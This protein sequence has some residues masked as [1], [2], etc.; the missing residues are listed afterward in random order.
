MRKRLAIVGGGIAGSYLAYLL[1]DEPLKINIFEKKKK[2]SLGKNCAWGLSLSHLRDF[3]FP[4]K[5]DDYILSDPNKDKIEIEIPLNGENFKTE[6]KLNNLVTID[7]NNFL[8]D[9]HEYLNNKSSIDID[10]ETSISKRSLE[11]YDYEMIVD[12]SGFRRDLLPDIIED[13]L[14]PCYQVRCKTKE[15][16]GWKAKFTGNGYLWRFP[17]N[18]NEVYIGCGDTIKNPRTCVEK[19]IKSMDIDI[20]EK[21]GSLIRLYPPQELSKVSTLGSSVVFGVGES[22]GT[23]SPITGE[24]IISSLKSA[25]I[26]YNFFD[27]LNFSK[28]SAYIIS[29]DFKIKRNKYED[30]VN[31]KFKKYKYEYKAFD[32]MKKNNLIS[33]LYN[34]I[35]MGDRPNVN[36]K[37]LQKMRIARMILKNH[38]KN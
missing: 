26:F 21:S 12:A 25:R 36:I 22:I 9:M 18:D 5:I 31:R 34:V 33:T 7:K 14:M 27:W 28:S 19:E 37:F 35:K 23:V 8:I 2:K 20:L 24:G 6:V 38:Q 30:L 4:L 15:D 1:S 32:A 29:K 11:S 3:D 17:L 13:K 16:L 10:Y